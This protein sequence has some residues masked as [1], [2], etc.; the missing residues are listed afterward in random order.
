MEHRWRQHVAENA[1]IQELLKSLGAAIGD[2]PTKAEL[3]LVEI[4]RQEAALCPATACNRFA[5]R[6]TSDSLQSPEKF[7]HDDDLL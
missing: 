3:E 2:S 6:I 1:G 4:W 7:I 5:S